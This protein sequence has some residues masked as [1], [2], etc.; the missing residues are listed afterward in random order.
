MNEPVGNIKKHL[1]EDL[2]IDP[3]HLANLQRNFPLIT[4]KDSCHKFTTLLQVY[5]DDFIAMAQTTDKTQLRHILLA[6][7]HSIHNVVLPPA[8]TG[9]DLTQDPISIKK[10]SKGDGVWK[11]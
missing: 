3:S 4:N 1:L 5:I 2:T 10:L 11:T 6:I 9:Q 7:M 8:V